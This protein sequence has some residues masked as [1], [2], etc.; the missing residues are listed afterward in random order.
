MAFK[1]FT[2][3][4]EKLIL[5][6]KVAI[7]TTFSSLFLSIT[8]TRSKQ[9]CSLWHVTNRVLFVRS[10]HLTFWEERVECNEQQRG[11][12]KSEK[13]SGKYF[14]HFEIIMKITSKTI[15]FCQ[16]KIHIYLKLII[17][18]QFSSKQRKRKIIRNKTASI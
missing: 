6:Y 14:L 17:V 16:R 8:A 9:K 12:L 4:V 5:P 1:S 3:I 15:T 11:I 10:R 2:S 13:M 7:D 18:Q